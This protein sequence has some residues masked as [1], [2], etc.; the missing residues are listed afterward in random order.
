MHRML[1]SVVQEVI[2]KVV[3]RRQRE[4]LRDHALQEL[5]EA[6]KSPGWFRKPD[7]DKLWRAVDQ[8]RQAGVEE[9]RLLEAERILADIEREK[10]GGGGNPLS[11]LFC[12]AHRKPNKRDGTPII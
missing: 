6:V 1:V 7:G 4:Q 8:A 3:K 12:A 2:R 11:G 10:S 9:D 5:A